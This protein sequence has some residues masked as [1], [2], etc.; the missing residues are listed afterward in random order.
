MAQGGLSAR[1]SA[2]TETAVDVLL[3]WARIRRRSSAQDIADFRGGQ[4]LQ[5]VGFTKSIGGAVMTSIGRGKKI[6]R[7]RSG[8]LRCAPGE[9]PVWTD[10]TGEKKSV[11]LR[12]PFALEP[13]DDKV[14]MAS[15]FERYELST[16]DG[17][18]DVIVPK[19][20]AELMRHVFGGSEAERRD[21]A[22]RV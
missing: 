16:A 4:P 19:K 12:P 11:L 18:Y 2:G 5:I 9:M 13:V 14:P 7:T 22:G 10:R 17:T 8:F 6:A 1:R 3:R 21:E 15:K 20:D